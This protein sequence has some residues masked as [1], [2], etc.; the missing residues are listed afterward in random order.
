MGMEWH[1][2]LF[3]NFFLLGL[4]G[5][6]LLCKA[7]PMSGS[8]NVKLTFGGET[9]SSIQILLCG[10]PSNHFEGLGEKLEQAKK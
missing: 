4:S 7:S 3:K 6:I 1:G 10:F 9:F 2:K 8:D 5:V